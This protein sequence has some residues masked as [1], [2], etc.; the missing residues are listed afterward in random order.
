MDTKPSTAALCWMNQR[1]LPSQ[2]RALRHPAAEFESICKEG[3]VNTRRINQEQKMKAAMSRTLRRRILGASL[4]TA[5]MMCTA[6]FVGATPVEK[7]VVQTSGITRSAIE[8]LQRWVSSGHDAWCLNAQ[9]VASAELRRLAPEFAGDQYEL[10]ALPLE[11][12]S[13]AATSVVYTYYSLDGRTSY[14]ITMRR[15][16]WLQAIAGNAR[17]IVWVPAKTEVISNE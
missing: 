13:H 11:T 8:N 4:L 15:Y 7:R 12:R 3:A 5:L 1:S 16:C 2:R 14:R 9:L 10:A 17:S 6:S